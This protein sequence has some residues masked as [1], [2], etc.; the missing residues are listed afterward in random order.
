MNKKERFLFNP[1]DP[2]KSFDLYIDKNKGDTIQIKY[3]N[4]KEVKDTI[5]KLERLY[6]S[7]K[8]SHV[9]ISQ[10]AMILRVRLKVIKDKNPSID[11]GRLK[12]A[13]RYS[14]FLKKRTTLKGD[15]ERKDM[16]FL[17]K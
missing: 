10:V 7:G 1:N 9:R 17:M 13:T 5:R 12:L 2:K 16:K 11:R 15:K 4:A 3:S 6:K 8:Y 14:E